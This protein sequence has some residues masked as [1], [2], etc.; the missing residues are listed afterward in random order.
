MSTSKSQP[1]AKTAGLLQQF[2]PLGLFADLTRQQA[3]VAADASC[4][5]FRGFEAMRRIQQQAAHQATVRHQA[6]AARLHRDCAPGDVLAIQ[7]EMAQGDWQ[8]A[9]QYWQQLAAAALEMQVEMMGCA[10]HLVDS[11]SALEAASAVEALDAIPMMKNIFAFQ[12]AR[13]QAAKRSG[14]R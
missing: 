13:A 8:S 7:A 6:L 14:A 2:A 10:S 3:S 11:E 4:A 9:T 12:P 5:M 1:A